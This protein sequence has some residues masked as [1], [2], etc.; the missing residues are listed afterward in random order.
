MHT[1]ATK[2]LPS[3]ATHITVQDAFIQVSTLRHSH[4]CFEI[5]DSETE[6]TIKFEQ[7]FTG[8]HERSCAHHLGI[9]VP[10]DSGTNRTLDQIVLVTDKSAAS[11][12]GLY[13]PPQ[14][15]YKNSAEVVFEACLPRTIIRLA[16]GNIRPPWRRPTNPSHP[17]PQGI[18]V[19][20]ILGACSDGTIYSLSILSKTARHLLRYLQ[21]IIEEKARRNPANHPTLVKPRSGA[22]HDIL[23]NNADGAQDDVIH[24]HPLDP[25]KSERS[26]AGPRW[27]HVDGDSLKRWL[28]EDGDLERL[29]TEGTDADVG[30]LLREFVREVWRLEEVQRWSGEEVLRKVKEWIGEVVME[31][32]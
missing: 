15:T 11:V 12:S 4:T 24:A 26:N 29:I 16:N 27:N 32:L 2:T 18:L 9:A 30:R 20:D 6:G 22:I 17:R 31:L 25:A 21:N 19:D 10:S 1:R 23:M 7:I 14:R 3:V 5:Q 28:E 8:S 13:Q